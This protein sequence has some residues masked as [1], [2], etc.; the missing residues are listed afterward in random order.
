MAL[1]NFT[2]T[3]IVE[4]V[5]LIAIKLWANKAVVVATVE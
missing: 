5:P 3:S 4:F 2:D 1:A